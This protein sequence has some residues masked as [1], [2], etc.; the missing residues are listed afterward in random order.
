MFLD[1]SGLSRVL[2]GSAGWHS[3]DKSAVSVD[4]SVSFS[5]EA[6][7]ASLGIA[8]GCDYCRGCAVW[9]NPAGVD[10]SWNIYNFIYIY[11]HDFIYI[12]IYICNERNLPPTSSLY[13]ISTLSPPPI[14]FLRPNA[15][16]ANL[17]GSQG[18]GGISRWAEIDSTATQL[19]P[20]R[21]GKP[22]LLVSATCVSIRGV[23]PLPLVFINL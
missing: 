2:C 14:L 10:V 8:G 16:P 21:P 5:L 6:T 3:R 19:Y 7:L 12:Y 22:P 17:D 9:A 15:H 23:P 18:K 1:S 20:S 11:I 13:I 4:L